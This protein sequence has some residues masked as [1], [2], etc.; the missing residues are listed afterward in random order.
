MK[1][2]RGVPPGLEFE[3]HEESFNKDFIRDFTTGVLNEDEFLIP[4]AKSVSSSDSSC[5]N[6]EIGKST[7]DNQCCQQTVFGRRRKLGIFRSPRACIGR[8]NRNFSTLR[9]IYS[10]GSCKLQ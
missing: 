4:V 6:L 9:E 8:R 10:C 2:P 7:S 3:W 1:A 5:G